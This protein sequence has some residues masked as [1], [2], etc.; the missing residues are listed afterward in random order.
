MDLSDL[1]R[2]RQ[3]IDGNLPDPEL[4]SV[5]RDLIKADTADLKQIFIRS[6]EGRHF[7][8]QVWERMSVLELKKEIQDK[9]GI[10]VALQNLVFSGLCLQDQHTLQHY[11][12]AK[13]S[14]IIL[15]HRLRGGSK[16]ATSKPTGN[17]HDAAK[18]KEPP[19]GKESTAANVPPGKYIVDQSPE[20]PSISMDLPEVKYIFSDLQKNA[21]ICRFNGFWP[22]TDAL[23]QWIP[24]SGQKTAKFTYVLRVSS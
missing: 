3:K 7:C 6:T 13:D 21:V 8:V 10:P 14:T 20:S 19:K 18:G 11:R 9:L 16:G 1:A 22:I 23:Y 24:R 17:Y 5:K 2:S 15:N 12:V 4:K